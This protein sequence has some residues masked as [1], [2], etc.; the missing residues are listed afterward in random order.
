MAAA[1]TLLNEVYAFL[2]AARWR[3]RS[4]SWTRTGAYCCYPVRPGLRLPSR[5][6]AWSWSWTPGPGSWT[7]AATTLLDE[8]C[9]FLRRRL[10][11]RL[12]G[13]GEW[14]A[15]GRELI[16]SAPLFANF[17]PGRPGGGGGRARCCS[18]GRRC[19]SWLLFVVDGGAAA[20]T[21]LHGFCTGA[22]VSS[23]K[24]FLSQMRSD[25]LH[26]GEAGREL[27]RTNTHQLPHAKHH[28][29]DGHWGRPS[30]RFRGRACTLLGGDASTGRKSTAKWLARGGGARLSAPPTT[31]W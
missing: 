17:E 3:A 10:R 1:T 8:V 5:R 2:R 24:G 6:Q 12:G 21:T 27:S 13:G 31:L 23:P 30:C 26:P 16:F 19:L 18:E 9:A 25:F 20:G 15:A 4:R 28:N 7:E 14:G 29:W 11:D 22:I